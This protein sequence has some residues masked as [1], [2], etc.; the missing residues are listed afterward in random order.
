MA[1]G[2]KPKIAA[3]PS[4]VA[5]PRELDEEVRRKDEA[6]RRQRIAAVGR[7]GTILTS[8]QSLSRGGSATIL[9]RST[10]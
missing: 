6:K 9:G 5:T 3:T 8:G 4:P 10:S 2:K 1:K 7:G